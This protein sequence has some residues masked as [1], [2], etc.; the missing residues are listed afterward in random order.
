MG[1]DAVRSHCDVQQSAPGEVR[2]ELSE[3]FEDQAM[4]RYGERVDAIAAKAAKRKH[5]EDAAERVILEFEVQDAVTDALDGPRSPLSIQGI[6]RTKA[7][8]QQSHNPDAAGYVPE[9]AKETTSMPIQ[10]TDAIT[11]TLIREDGLTELR[12]FC[13]PLPGDDPEVQEAI[14]TLSRLCRGET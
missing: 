2:R 14:D 12:E 8:E 3:L 5:G 6:T 7:P 1:L 4:S 13:K 9:W 11:Q 10:P